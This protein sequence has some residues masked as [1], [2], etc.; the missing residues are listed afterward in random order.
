MDI[1]DFF[2][3]PT[4]IATIIISV[5]IVVGYWYIYTSYL[6]DVSIIVI[7]LAGISFV[8]GIIVIIILLENPL[9]IIKY[10]K[11]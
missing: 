9:E 10:I 5:S 6:N 11:K 1:M 7:L 8:A 3:I 2:D 4:L